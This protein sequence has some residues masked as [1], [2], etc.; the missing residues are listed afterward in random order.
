[1]KWTIIQDYLFWG[2]TLW[3]TYHLWAS[4]AVSVSVLLLESED[5][6][7]TSTTPIYMGRWQHNCTKSLYIVTW[8]HGPL[9]GNGWLNRFLQQQIHKQLYWRLLGVIF[10]MWSMPRSCNE[11]TS[12]VIV[13]HIQWV[14]SWE[15]VR[16]LPAGNDISSK[17]EVVAR[18]CYQANNW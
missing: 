11:A 6:A 18:I 1:M 7:N 9:L 17:A 3:C 4:D 5:S 15:L 13:S 16:E 14:T 12:W 2:W 10:S 8:L